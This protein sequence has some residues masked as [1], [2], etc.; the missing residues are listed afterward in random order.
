MNHEKPQWRFAAAFGIIIVLMMMYVGAFYF[1]VNRGLDGEP[2]FLILREYSPSSRFE[3]Y[4]EMPA[5]ETFFR[6]II[7][8]DRRLHPAD[9]HIE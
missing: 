1:M 7:W 4:E 2:Y 6:P 3:S 5:L 9:W 8:V